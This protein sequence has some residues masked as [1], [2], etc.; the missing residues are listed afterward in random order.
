MA[1]VSHEI[2][3]EEFDFIRTIDIHALPTEKYEKRKQDLL[4]NDVE[5]K[6]Q[7]FQ[8]L[9]KYLFEMSPE[10]PKIIHQ[11]W[12]GP[13]KKPDHWINTWKDEYIKANPEWKHM[14]WTD[15]ELDELDMFNKEI[16]KQETTYNG[17]SDVARYEILY[18]YGGIYIDADSIWLGSK[19]MDD[20]IRKSRNTCIFLGKEPTKDYA[21][22]GVVGASKGHPALLLIIKGIEKNFPFR[23][24]GEQP[25][26]TCGP[27]ILHTLENNKI[28]VVVFPKEYFYP[29]YW[30]GKRFTDISQELKD[31][32][33]SES[34]MYQYGY[35]TNRLNELFEPLP[36][37][38]IDEEMQHI[39]QQMQKLM[40]VKDKMHPQQFQ[41][42]IALFTRRQ[43]ELNEML[44]Y[45]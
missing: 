34:Y 44:S 6:K 33:K 35:T 9:N 22:S 3:Q 2:T 21:A 12:I 30:H 27:L 14:M 41:Q 11:T 5:K 25:W 15:A 29:E 43:N 28:P 8:I 19:S 31:K 39:A 13:N 17:K 7:F 16:Y 37:E 20:L 18:K 23:L 1:E 38:K 32:Y 42:Y 40:Q 26:I 36:K 24:M 4:I 10:I 45:D